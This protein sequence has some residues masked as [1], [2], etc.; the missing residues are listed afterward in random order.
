MAVDQQR[1]V[2]VQKSLKQHIIALLTAASWISPE[3]FVDIGFISKETDDLPVVGIPAPEVI[4]KKT[5]I[6]S[7]VRRHTFL[8][9]IEV[10]GKTGGQLTA[11][12]T[13]IPPPAGYALW[14]WG[15]EG[16]GQLGLGDTIKRS[17]LVQ[18]LV[19]LVSPILFTSIQVLLYYDIITTSTAVR[20]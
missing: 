17:S 6:G 11:K 1:T 8:V 2:L 4:G 3:D 18:V 12:E 9:D 7:N 15:D 16:S 14:V 5:E 13:I 20:T 19:W 10:K